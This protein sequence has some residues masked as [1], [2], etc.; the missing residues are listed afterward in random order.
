MGIRV[1]QLDD[2]QVSVISTGLILAHSKYINNEDKQ[3]AVLADTLI[4]LIQESE[5]FV[6]EVKRNE[7]K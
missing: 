6:S 5:I 1:I 2:T 7:K 3:S 4:D